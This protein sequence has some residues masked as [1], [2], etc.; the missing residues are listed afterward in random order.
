MIIMLTESILNH[1]NYKLN[2]FD[3]GIAKCKK[4]SKDKC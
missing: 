4:I 3:N 2:L 1:A